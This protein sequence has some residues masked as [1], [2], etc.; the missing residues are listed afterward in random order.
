MI[1]FSSVQHLDHRVGPQKVKESSFHLTSL[2]LTVFFGFGEY[3]RVSKSVSLNEPANISSLCLQVCGL[4]YLVYS[5]LDTVCCA[6]L[7]SHG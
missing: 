4:Q 7:P 2:E 5:V 3:V 1:V 6:W